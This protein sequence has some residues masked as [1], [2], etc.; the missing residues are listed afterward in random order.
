MSAQPPTHPWSP[1]EI[2]TRSLFPLVALLLLGLLPWI[3]AYA[4]LIATFVWWRIVTRI[5]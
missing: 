3:G 1:T 4:F 5:G 2:L